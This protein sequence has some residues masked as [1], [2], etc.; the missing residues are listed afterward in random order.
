MKEVLASVSIG[1]DRGDGEDEGQEVLD[2]QRQR[3][4]NHAYRVSI[5][6]QDMHSP[7]LRGYPAHDAKQKRIN[8]E[9]LPPASTTHTGWSLN[10]L[11]PPL[12]ILQH[13]D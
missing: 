2:K 12:P 5:R 1:I 3:M 11:A 10:S 8:Q 4:G 7:G 6:V 9:I 13:L